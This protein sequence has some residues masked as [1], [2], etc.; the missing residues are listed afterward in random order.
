V[1]LAPGATGL[2]LRLDRPERA[3][4]VLQGRDLALQGALL[5]GGHFRL[6]TVRAVERRQIPGNARI[7]LGQAPL[8]L[9]G[10]EV[11]VAIVDRLELA[12]INGYQRP[13]WLRTACTAVIPVVT[14]I[15]APRL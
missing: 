9:G 6:G 5:Q 15:R 11:L 7:D 2:H 10:G 13:S 4:L 1:R 8:E 14:R 12:A 3:H